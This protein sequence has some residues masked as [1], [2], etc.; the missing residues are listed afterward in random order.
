MKKLLALVAVTVFTNGAFA[1][2][3]S[4][5]YVVESG[6]MLISGQAAMDLYQDLEAKEVVLGGV[7]RQETR[8]K[9]GKSIQCVA[10]YITGLK[11][12]TDAIKEFVLE[13]VECQIKLSSMEIG[14][15]Y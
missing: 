8:Q 15:R 1:A 9:K 12:D 13:S 2:E 7:T 14:P 4:S 10:N 3:S 5:D 11:E 6:T